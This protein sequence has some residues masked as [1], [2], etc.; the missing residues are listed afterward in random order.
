MHEAIYSVIYKISDI[1]SKILSW[2]NG[3]EGTLTDKQ[4]HFWVIGIVGMALLLVVY[5]LFALLAKRHIL[6]VAWLYVFTLM[7]VMAFA[8]EIGQGYTGTGVMDF[9]DIVS[10]LTGFMYL[11]VIF[12][13]IKIIFSVILK[14]LKPA[15]KHAS[16]DT[17]HDRYQTRNQT[18][19]P[20]FKAQTYGRSYGRNRNT[21]FRTGT[22]VLKP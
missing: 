8:I 18:R 4:L 21:S 7:V 19:K 17:Y 10:G 14:V 6:V 16:D 15:K 9:D 3:Y 12:A 22:Y 11:F 1:H 13:V 20:A 2:N 5:P